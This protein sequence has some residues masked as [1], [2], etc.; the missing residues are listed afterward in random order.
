VKKRIALSV[1]FLSLT[2]V[3]ALY[4]EDCHRAG[5]LIG[6][7]QQYAETNLPAAE[8]LLREA[9]DLCDKSASIHYNL[10]GVY[11]ASGDT[12]RARAEFERALRLKPDY[13]NAM[14]A[15][16]I[17]LFEK[18]EREYEHALK[19]ARRA[20]M[21]E[22]DNRAVR[23]VYEQIEGYVDT[24]IV[25]AASNADAIAVVIGNRSYSAAG[26]PAVEYADHDADTVRK[27]L[28]ST[29]GFRE[30]NIIYRKDARYTDLL[31]IFGDGRDHKG[32]LYNFAKQ[33][34]S[35]IFIFYSGHGAPDTDSKKAF[36]APVDLNPAA[37]RHTSYPLDQLYENLGKLSREKQ[38]RSVTIVLDACF[39]GASERGMIV[40]DASPLVMQIAQPALTIDNAAIITSSRGDQ[41]S[42]WYPEQKH[43]L[44]TYYF[45][46]ALRDIT[47]NGE[48]LTVAGIELKLTGADGVNS[49]ALRLHSREQMP[50]VFGAKNIALVRGK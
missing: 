3:P 40:K 1:L 24:P 50:Q 41:I 25:T 48:P 7:A 45:L 6:E 22:P 17:L 12:G 42:S 33:G 39:S 29:L 35:D 19:L 47:A 49:S 8:K 28:V 16:A 31:T 27:Y 9:V 46:K 4:A 11:A 18:K 2:T 21:L 38:V 36:L 14:S 23:E 30:K 5:Q 15:Q 37:I 43:G 44:F 34:K 26:I 20:V 10:G 32:L 13:A